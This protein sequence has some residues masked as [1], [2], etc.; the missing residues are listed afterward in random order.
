MK[1]LLLAVFFV[2][3]SAQTSFAYIDPGTGSLIVSSVLGALA[4]FTYT[5][6]NFIQKFKAFL[7]SP[8]KNVTRTKAK[9]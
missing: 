7:F 2:L 9:N 3:T 5:F 6:R 4:A 1:Y 8:K